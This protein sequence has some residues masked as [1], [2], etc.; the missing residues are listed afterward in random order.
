MSWFSLIKEGQMTLF[1]QMS[2][3]QNLS[4]VTNT[5]EHYIKVF[6]EIYCE[7]GN[8]TNSYQYAKY[9]RIIFFLRFH[10]H[11]CEYLS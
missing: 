11:D 3:P 5:D 10:V 1:D 6:P 9:E 7:N 4:C 2:E 8:H